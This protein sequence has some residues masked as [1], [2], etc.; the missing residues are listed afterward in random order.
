MEA[1]MSAMNTLMNALERADY[2]IKMNKA[3]V[4]S[5]YRHHFHLMPP[6]GWM[7][8]P[9][10]FCY[11]KGEYH[12]FYQYY[13]YGSQWGPMHWGHAKSQDMLTWEHLPVALAPSEAYDKNGIFSGTALVVGDE[14]RVYYTG[15]VDTELDKI[16]DEQFI[17][18]DKAMKASVLDQPVARQVQCLAVSTDGIHFEKSLENPVLDTKDIPPSSRLEDFRDPKIWEHD[19][20]FYLAAGS[21]RH[22]AVGQVLFYDSEDGV[23]WQYLNALTLNRD[24]GTVWECPDF[25]ELDGYQVLLFSPQ[26]KPR[27]GLQYENVHSALAFIGAFDYLTGNFTIKFIQEIDGGFDF[28]AP[29]T[30]LDEEGNRVMVAWMNM[31]ERR[32]ILNETHQGWNG[33]MTLPRTLSIRNNH[34]YQWPIKAIETYRQRLVSY[35][36]LVITNTFSNPELCGN[37]VDIEL[38]FELLS[39]QV[40]EIRLFENASEH[41]SLTF[42]KDLKTVVLNRMQ[43][44]QPIISL[45]AKNDFSRSV[46]QDCSGRLHV[47]ILLD[48]SSAEVFLQQGEQTMSTLFFPIAGSQNISF[49]ADGQVMM[50]QMSLWQLS[51]PEQ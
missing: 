48:V 34:L 10:G 5:D 40:F 51:M 7:N 15:M 39:G 8:D 30:L 17:K 21:K 14:L 3:H 43:T 44:F 26:E 2:Y 23:H 20:K 11:Y 33:S 4:K 12:L 27:C 36:N 29:Q 1:S 19:N 46:S 13:P 38:D 6:I 47:R 42:H 22:E 18:R 24:F 9:N 32:Y 49:M 41:L 25:F 37:V 50:H 31:W 28:Y 35:Q 16:Y 45:D